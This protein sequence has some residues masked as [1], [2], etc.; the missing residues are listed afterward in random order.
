[1]AVRAVEW[2]HRGD[3]ATA[4]IP[5]A[6]P[7]SPRFFLKESRKA[8]AMK[9][10]ERYVAAQ[11]QPIP[12]DVESF[13]GA[14]NRLQSCIATLAENLLTRGELRLSDARRADW[15]MFAVTH[16][17]DRIVTATRWPSRIEFRP[18]TNHNSALIGCTAHEAAFTLAAILDPGGPDFDISDDPEL[19]NVEELRHL[20]AKL[21]QECAILK[22]SAVASEDSRHG[23]ETAVDLRGQD[24]ACALLLAYPHWPDKRI[25]DAV[26]CSRTT[27]YRWPR[28]QAARAAQRGQLPRGSKTKDGHLEAWHDG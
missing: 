8:V 20:I 22:A 27:L 15:A 13:L 19:W 4:R 11:R 1:M 7:V 16:W 24:K 25:A 18:W 10:S 28:F 9:G 17:K 14:S 2:N 5:V 21:D 3:R 26:G 6:L 23:E 12:M